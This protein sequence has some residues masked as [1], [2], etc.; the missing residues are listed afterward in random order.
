MYIETAMNISFTQ[1]KHTGKPYLLFQ[2][3]I[4]QQNKETKKQR[5]KQQQQ[6]VY[7]DH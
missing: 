6:L 2:L 4:P 1:Q 3:A 5:N 7:F